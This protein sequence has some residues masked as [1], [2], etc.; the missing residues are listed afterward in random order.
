MMAREIGRAKEGLDSL[1]VIRD[2]NHEIIDANLS[3]GRPRSHAGSPLGSLMP[4]FRNTTA[5]L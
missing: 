5:Y 1:G 2:P 3:D 4:D